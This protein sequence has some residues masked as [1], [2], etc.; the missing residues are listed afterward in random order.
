MIFAVFAEQITEIYS[1]MCG[2]RYLNSL[3]TPD[4][5]I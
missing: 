4:I 1:C 5:G 2:V 3:L